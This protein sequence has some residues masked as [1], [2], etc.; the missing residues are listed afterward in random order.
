MTFKDRFS[1]QAADYGKYRPNYP[2]EL[3]AYV[4]SLATSREY[5]WDCGTGNGQAAV[6]LAEFFERVIATNAS[7]KQILSAEQNA[8]VQYRVAPA[9]KKRSQLWFNGSDYGSS[10]TALV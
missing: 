2:Q 9:R 4:T 3:F 8:R 6:G 7:A 5:A 10:S 1:E